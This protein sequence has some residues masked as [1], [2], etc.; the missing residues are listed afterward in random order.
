MR[1]KTKI[2]L[3]SYYLTTVIIICIFIFC[4]G[5]GKAYESMVYMS[6]GEKKSAVRVTDSGIRILDFEIKF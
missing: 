5:I 3:K 6:S 1:L 2:F 4:Y